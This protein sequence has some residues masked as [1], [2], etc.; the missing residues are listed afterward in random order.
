MGARVHETPIEDFEQ[1]L[2][3]NLRPAYLVANAA[4]PALL[5]AG[6]GAIVLVS[7]RAAVQPFA[8]AA[9]YITSKAAVL[10]FTKALATE[11]KDDGI[12]VNAVLPS[13]IGTPAALDGM[14]PEQAARAVPPQEIAA[15]IRFLCSPESAPVSGAEVPVYGKA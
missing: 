12:R 1:Q 15:V 4:I 10:A 14:S 9:G 3:L 5:D 6:G 7:S 11:Y 2:Q 8:N 13:V